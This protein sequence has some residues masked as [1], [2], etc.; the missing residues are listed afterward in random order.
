MYLRDAH[1]CLSGNL[2]THSLTICLRPTSGHSSY[3][4]CMTGSQTMKRLE[5]PSQLLN[6]PH[7]SKKN[8]GNVSDAT[9]ILP[10]W[11]SPQIPTT[12]TLAKIPLTLKHSLPAICRKR[13]QTE[14][15]G[16]LTKRNNAPSRTGLGKL[17]L[18]R[19]PQ[20]FPILSGPT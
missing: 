2:S 4:A 6:S 10:H 16:S 1:I 8:T 7:K 11:H 18:S 20:R 5:E 13:K 12:N 19:K 14:H 9:P 17:N 15:L 3:L